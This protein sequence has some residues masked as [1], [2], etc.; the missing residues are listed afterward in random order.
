M[1]IQVYVVSH[2]EED[3]QD[4]IVYLNETRSYFKECLAMTQKHVDKGII[5]S[6]YAIDA[7]IDQCNRFLDA[8]ENEIIKVV[9]KRID[10]FE[11]LSYDKK[12]AYKKQVR[13][14]VNTSVIPAYQDVVKYFTAL[15]GTQKN[16]GALCNWNDGKKYYE[17]LLRYHTPLT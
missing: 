15:K 13:D 2:S 1:K 11:P 8:K 17:I 3:I 9:S 16:N 12:Q 5:Q 6:D 7:I 4:L 10:A 14:A